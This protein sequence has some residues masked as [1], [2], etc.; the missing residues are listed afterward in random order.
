LVAAV[1]D[2]RYRWV[3]TLEPSIAVE[4][5]E[6]PMVPRRVIDRFGGRG[7]VEGDQGSKDFGVR[8][9]VVERERSTRLLIRRR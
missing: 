2:R 8:S 5:S 1:I 4:V 7:F 6:L 3:V 9:A